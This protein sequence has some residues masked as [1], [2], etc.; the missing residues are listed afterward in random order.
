MAGKPN[1]HYL[2][3]NESR[4]H[5]EIFPPQTG[6]NCLGRRDSVG[7]WSRTNRAAGTSHPRHPGWTGDFGHGICVGAPMVAFVAGSF[8]QSLQKYFFTTQATV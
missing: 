5:R 6:G 8:I 7:R 1:R 3:L 2:C 4:I